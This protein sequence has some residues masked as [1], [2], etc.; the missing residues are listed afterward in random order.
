MEKN[1]TL[2]NVLFGKYETL[3]HQE[4]LDFGP[5]Y[6]D[7]FFENQHLLLIFIWTE[8]YIETAD[9]CTQDIF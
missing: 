7:V 8:M 4:K 6:L 2:I 5:K 3:L 9:T 1:I